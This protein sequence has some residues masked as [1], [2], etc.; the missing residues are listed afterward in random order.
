VWK[1]EAEA[2][3]NDGEKKINQEEKKTGQCWEQQVKGPKKYLGRDKTSLFDI[4]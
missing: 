2:T 1:A 4:M 3:K